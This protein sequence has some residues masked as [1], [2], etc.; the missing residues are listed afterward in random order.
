VGVR[1]CDAHPSLNSVPGL[2][3]LPRRP[4]TNAG[5]KLAGSAGPNRWC[6]ALSGPG[7]HTHS[8]KLWFSPLLVLLPPGARNR[9]DEEGAES[10]A[11]EAPEPVFS[12]LSSS[13]RE[14]GGHRAAGQ[15]RNVRPVP[16]R[17]GECRQ[18]EY[19]SVS[20][21][22]YTPDNRQRMGPVLFEQLQ[23]LALSGILRPEHM[24]L[25]EGTVRWVPATEVKGLFPRSPARPPQA[26]DYPGMRRS[27]FLLRSRRKVRMILDAGGFGSSALGR[28]SLALILCALLFGVSLMLSFAV[29]AASGTAIALATAILVAAFIPFLVLVLGQSDDEVTKKIESLAASLPHAEAAWRERKSQLGAEWLRQV[30][31]RAEQTIAMLQKAP[32]DGRPLRPVVVQPCPRYCELGI[33]ATVLSAFGWLILLIG[34]SLPAPAPEHDAPGRFTAFS[35]LKYWPSALQLS[36]FGS[37]AVCGVLP[38]RV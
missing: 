17:I 5:F 20:R 24:V 15:A 19:L 21:W 22:Y 2:A 38:G 23:Q 10:G 30:R 35:V 33:V 18:Q 36:V 8:V 14:N 34:F 1:G 25:C 3:V 16:L 12:C 27:L 32:G 6:P 4:R 9:K 31:S 28:L 11:R 13:G 26:H 29:H 7:P 37:P